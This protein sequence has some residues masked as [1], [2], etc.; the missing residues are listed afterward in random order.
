MTWS[1]KYPFSWAETIHKQSTYC[2][3]N[4]FLSRYDSSCIH[5]LMRPLGHIISVSWGHWVFCSSG[6][7]L[8]PLVKL[9][10]LPP[11]Y[12]LWLFSWLAPVIPRVPQALLKE[13]PANPRLPTSTGMHLVLHLF[14]RQSSAGT[15]YVALFLSSQKFVTIPVH[16]AVKEQCE[17]S[18]LVSCFWPLVKCKSNIYSPPF[19]SPVSTNSWGK[20]LAL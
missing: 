18:V 15:W 20:Y 14:L 5:L 8:T 4:L 3:Y 6:I 11:H 7:P 1:Q 9:S 2:T 13:W 17:R 19:H 10:L 12:C 16:T